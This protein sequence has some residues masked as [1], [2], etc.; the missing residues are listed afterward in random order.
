MLGVEYNYTPESN[1]GITENTG[2]FC[3]EYI[4]LRALCGGGDTEMMP[5]AHKNDALFSWC[6]RYIPRRSHHII[7]S[8]L[9]QSQKDP[10][11]M[12]FE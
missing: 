2:N 6:N 4:D 12:R 3:T 5:L 9:K 7:V 8:R 1:V 11:L 10:K